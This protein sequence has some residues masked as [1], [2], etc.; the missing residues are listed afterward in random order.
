MVH[1][2][3]FLYFILGCHVPQ[4]VHVYFVNYACVPPVAHNVCS[5][6]HECTTRG[7]QRGELR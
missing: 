5:E 2:V 4:V 7:T 6:N 3:Y 1:D